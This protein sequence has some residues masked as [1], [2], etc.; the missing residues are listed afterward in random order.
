MLH[1]ARMRATGW[2]ARW[3]RAFGAW[4]R[5]QPPSWSPRLNDQ[6][7][8]N[9]VFAHEPGAVHALP[10]EWNLQYHAYMAQVRLCGGV[11]AGSGAGAGADVDVDVNCGAALARGIFVCP[12][13]PAIVH[14]M[15]QSYRTTTPSYYSE[16]WDAASK[17]PRALLA[18][19]H[20]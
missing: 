6:D 3:R 14:F 12:R 19:A 9:A 2:E 7:V 5:E 16:Y 20:T 13:P 10:C 1:L 15:A 17:V 11:G 4:Q 8:F 18:C